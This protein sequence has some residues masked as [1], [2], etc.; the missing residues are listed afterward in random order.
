MKYFQNVVDTVR[1]LMSA[2]CTENSY[3]SGMRKNADGFMDVEWCQSV[4]LNS[5]GD[6]RKTFLVDQSTA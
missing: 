3:N 1:D 2:K 4:V 6:L 5:W